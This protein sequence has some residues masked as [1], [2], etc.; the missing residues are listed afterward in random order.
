MTDDIVE[1]IKSRCRLEVVLE[2]DGYSLTGTGRYRR[3]SQNDSLVV[4][5]HNQSY[6][7]NSRSEH[8]D[9]I[10]WVRARKNFDFKGAV[11]DLCSR[12][13]I[14]E[15]NWEHDDMQT[16]I[17]AR[18]KAD[19]FSAA[20][21]VFQTWLAEDTDALAYAASRGWTSETIEA[22]RLGYTGEW[23]QRGTLIKNLRGSLSHEGLDLE[24]PV[25]VSLIGYKGDL[26]GWG[27]KHQ[28]TVR[29]EWVDK[30]EILG[31][32]GRDM[33]IYPHSV[34][35]RV[36]YFSGRGVKEK[37]HY[38]LP[39]ELV[40]ER[41]PYFNA[42]WSSAEDE[43]V[44]VEGQACAISLQQLGIPAV[45][46]AGTAIG[47]KLPQKL[48]HHKAI[49][50]GLDRDAAGQAGTL[51]GADALGPMTRLITWY[52]RG[53]SQDED[54]DANELLKSM[55]KTGYAQ[56]DMTSLLR[57]LMDAS[58]TYAERLAEQVG[59]SSGAMR[60][61]ALRTAMGVIGKLDEITMAQYRSKL[62]KAMDVNIRDF[63]HVLKTMQ[64]RAEGDQKPISET[65]VLGGYFDGW[66]LEYLYDP[67]TD[68]AKFA[69][70]DPNGEIGMKEQLD[71]NGTRYYPTM[72]NKFIRGG[73][74]MFASNLG[75][76]KSTRELVGMV[77]IFIR[78][79]YLLP[80]PKLGR[81]IAYYVMLTWVF[82]CFNSLPYL[83]AVG[84]TGAG[85][86]ELMRRV[87]SICYRLLSAT[88]ANS[89]S[90]FF[91]A[92][93][94]YRGTVFI[95]E[96]D[97]ADGGDMANDIVKFLNLGAM[98]G[99]PIWR[100]E[101]VENS[102]GEKGYEPAIFQTFCPK[103]I[104]MR[105]D[106]R[107]Q[108]VASRCVTISLQPM[109]PYEL[110]QAGVGLN[111][112]EA[113][114]AKA[115]A[116]RNLLIRW[117]MEHWQVEIPINEDDIDLEIS[118]RLN[119][120][121]TPLLALASDDPEL[122]RE[123]RDYLRMYNS[124]IVLTRS[125]SIAAR[126]IEAMWKIYKYPDLRFT[127]VQ[128]NPLGDEYLMIGDVAK[129]ANEIMDEM[130]DI[131]DEEEDEGKKFKRKKDALTPRGCGAIIRMEL[132]LKVGR[133]LNRGFPVVWDQTRMEALGK[134]YG[135]EYEAI[136]AEKASQRQRNKE[137]E[138]ESTL[139]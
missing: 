14:E 69:Y 132:Q 56:K 24:S 41:Q 28:V 9:V 59:T 104:A 29:Q 96:A 92:T 47:E 75:P 73:G 43:C 109:E 125:M 19:A 16:R 114:R 108:A 71:I 60:D 79:N 126:V 76:T 113:F 18:I 123:I 65:E 100:L 49:Y 1:T 10:N 8:G 84:D 97:L 26:K 30:G 83:R 39:G 131:D 95:D 53:V 38:N 106:F 81:L 63:N 13:G 101:E 134:R 137:A 138:H 31:L 94:K 93:E 102:L 103:L 115:L 119:Q 45:A 12:F 90:S 88:G 20:A 62:A 61:Q 46:L 17:S 105:K 21:A 57:E 52:K 110:R 98:K 117:R 78:Q 54:K 74:V 7:W 37:R 4:D 87:G 42:V 35:G 50:L 99:N 82:D 124:E 51:K 91:R 6:H 23:D 36:V 11:I 40:G 120:V 127:M 66:L 15:P 70:R 58:P 22:A 107:D 34:D 33:L 121:T 25:C 32:V 89:A 139:F 3:A 44:V 72:P 64:A 128:K 116:L 48:S 2:Q 136:A 5:L 27:L 85:K 130:N 133:R 80:D 86:S 122:K 111:I 118:S 112:D 67:E 129:I 68:K 55:I 135:I 77:E